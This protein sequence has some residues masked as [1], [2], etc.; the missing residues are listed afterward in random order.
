MPATEIRILTK[1]DAA[2]YWHLRLEAL[3]REP[4]SFGE[5]AE[6]HRQT[7]VESA[8][9][10]LATNPDDN[11]VFGAFQAGELVGM[12][13]FFRYQ[14]AKARHKGRI[15]GVYVRASGRGQG[16]GRALLI[17]LLEK[18]KCCPGLEQV[19]LTVVS[20]QAAARA[21]YRS[22]GFEPYGLEPRGLKVGGRYLDNEYMVLKLRESGR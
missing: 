10:R 6:E 18:V 4:E 19:T 17:A 1:N 2:A 11:F 12:A 20:G 16:I 13:G 15:W 3:E 21:L 7:T 22:R 9:E 14:I 8:A 5:A